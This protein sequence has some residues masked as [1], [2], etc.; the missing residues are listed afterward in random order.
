MPTSKHTNPEYH[1]TVTDTDSAELM[2]MVDLFSALGDVTRL[3]L[4][5]ALMDGPLCVND[6]VARCAVSESAVSHQLRSLRMQRLITPQRQ[7]QKV[8]YSLNDEH[9]SQLV[10]ICLEHVR[11][12][13]R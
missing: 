6:L 12:V 5:M 4:L 8:Y 7:G 3:R 11:E 2:D 1:P 10:R 13:W 9:V